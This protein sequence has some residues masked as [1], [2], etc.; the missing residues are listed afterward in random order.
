MT[1]PF[2]TATPLNLLGIICCEVST[3]QRAGNASCDCCPT[4]R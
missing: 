3:R 2:P 4:P 1:D